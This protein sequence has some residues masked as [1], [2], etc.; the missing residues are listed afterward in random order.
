MTPYWTY[1]LAKTIIYPLVNFIIVVACAFCANNGFYKKGFILLGIAFFLAF[2]ENLLS[3][4]LSFEVSEKSNFRFSIWWIDAMLS[5]L[6]PLIIVSGFLT[7]SRDI[8]R[9]TK[10]GSRL[11]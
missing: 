3:T 9:S 11:I 2:V 10:S 5:L 6:V 7:I 1:V 4:I 8:A